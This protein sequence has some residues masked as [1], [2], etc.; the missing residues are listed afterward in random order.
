[1]SFFMGRGNSNNIAQPAMDIGVEHFIAE[2][3][4]TLF[5]LNGE[6]VQ[7][8]NRIT[9]IVGGV[10]QF[11]PFNFEETSTKSITLAEGVPIGTSVIIR[12]IK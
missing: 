3:G 10:E 5:V 4:Q 9:I 8:K 11:T 7:N 12:Y 1:M 6:Y 2:E